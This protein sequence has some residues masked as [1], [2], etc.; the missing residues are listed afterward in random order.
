MGS[1]TLIDILGSMF[2]GGLLILT[3][4]NMNDSATKNTFQSQE[5]LTVQQNMTSIIQNLQW[6]FR[7]IGYCTDPTQISDPKYFIL[8]G[9]SDSVVF[10]ADMFDSGHTD[11]VYWYLGN[12]IPGP[13]PRIRQLCRRVGQFGVVDSANLGVTEF[14]LVYYD[15]CDSVMKKV[16]APQANIPQLI[17]L[18]VRVEPT[19]A[20]DTA[21]YQNFSYWRQTRL[22]SRNLTKQR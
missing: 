3:A 8:F 15:L 14:S 2:I 18:T 7:K 11:T 1:T 21:Y 20:Y 16:V 17:E 12:I 9:D 5:N 6:D 19:A 4:L 13:N 22:V 10:R